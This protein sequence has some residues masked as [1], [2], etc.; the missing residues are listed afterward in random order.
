M[1]LPRADQ[2]LNPDAQEQSIFVAQLWHE[3]LSTSSP[4][5]FRAKAL[6]LPLLMEELLK[7][8]HYAQQEPKWLSHVRLICEEIK[9]HQ[10]ID[11]IA[12]FPS[13]AE[14]VLHK[15]S[16]FNLGISELPRL[17]EQVRIF[18][19][20]Y[21]SYLP[22]LIDKTRTLASDSKRKKLL[23]TCMST[24]ATHVQ[25]HGAADETIAKI[26]EDICELQPQEII[27][28][29]C[30]DISVT[31]RNYCC[32]IEISAPRSTASS[33]FS[34][35]Q[36]AEVGSNTFSA[37]VIATKW[38]SQR[39]EG[40]VVKSSVT[41][42]SRRKAAELALAEV[43]SLV[44]LHALYSNNVMVN[45]SPEVLVQEEDHFYII[46]VTPSRHFGLEPRRGSEQ[47]SRDRYQH[48]GKRLNGRLGN[49]LESHAL[50]VSAKDARSAVFH[51]WT[52]LETL[53]SGLGAGSIGEGVADAIAPI[54]AWKRIDKIVTYL[55][56]SGHQFQKHT[57]T[58]FDF[59][60]MP[61]ST[62]KQIDRADILRAIC[63][64][65]NNISILSSF[66]NFAKNPLLKYR[67]YRA[68]EE[69][70]VP[71][72][73]RNA[74]VLSQRRIRW[75]IM[76]FYRARNLLVHYGE[77][78]NLALRLLEDAQY[79]L[80]TCVGRVLHDF[81]IF[82]NWDINSSL[83]FQRHRY[84]SLVDRTEAHSNEVKLDELLVNPESAYAKELA[85][86]KGNPAN[87]K[88]R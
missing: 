51:L 22:S 65:E 52:A 35:L 86:P 44:Y 43:L 2:L 84:E 61:R 79:Y 6:D 14:S 13:V 8:C 3:L 47:L 76:R 39:R 80:S 66:N 28:K 16:N 37:N 85:W 33:L 75:Q 17:V 73:L 59:T 10:I 34:G 83:E 78:D 55:A 24:L 45:A 5:S 31:A 40:I 57:G 7:I 18:L 74:L 49:V 12:I 63:G 62:K 25:A 50:A 69:C 1:W 71:M 26:D 60:S 19:D 87:K 11:G 32:F 42:L 82:E 48:L 81:S 41:A 4:D 23:E 72:H 20:L 67:L 9:S 46:D 15:I 70:H 30:G 68:W 56:I 36:F 27:E 77:V 53:A 58:V 54:I 88:V 38:N 29:L 64:E 21:K